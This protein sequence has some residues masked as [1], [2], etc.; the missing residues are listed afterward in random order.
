MGIQL[1]HQEAV[2]H[3]LREER[4]LVTEGF[5]DEDEGDDGLAA[6]IEPE[7][8]QGIQRLL[9]GLVERQVEQEAAV[10]LA[11]AL[12]HELVG[13]LM[14]VEAVKAVV[15]RQVGAEL[16]QAGGAVLAAAGVLPPG[17]Q[18][19]DGPQRHR[20]QNDGKDSVHVALLSFLMRV[21]LIVTQH[22][23]NCVII[24]EKFQILRQPVPVSRAGGSS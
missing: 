17:E 24:F 4:L 15:Q 12:V 10:V 20:Q 21:F 2:Q 14:F 1:L 13:V 5:P 9:G 23:G 6:G 22:A 7:G 8:V 18:Q 19:D 11:A 3:F 16:A